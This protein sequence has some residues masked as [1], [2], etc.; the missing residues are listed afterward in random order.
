MTNDPFEDQLT[1]EFLVVDDDNICT[2]L[3]AIMLKPYGMVTAVED[4]VFAVKAVQQRYQ[5]GGR[6]RVPSSWIFLCR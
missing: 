5:Q 2:R 1:D 3:A 4:G 6:Y